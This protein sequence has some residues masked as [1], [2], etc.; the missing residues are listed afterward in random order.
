M[1]TFDGFLFASSMQNEAKSKKTFPVALV[2][3]IAVIS[4]LYLM[5]AIG[6]IE[7][8]SVPPLFNPATAGLTPNTDGTYSLTSVD[9]LLYTVNLTTAEIAHLS[10]LSGGTG[11][12]VVPLW[13]P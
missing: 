6:T 2:T 7:T 5:I 9:G 13:R 12:Q 3:G 4:I 8:S 10:G 1:F 11:T